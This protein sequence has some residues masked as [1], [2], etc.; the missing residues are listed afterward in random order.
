MTAASPQSAWT[1]NQRSAVIASFLG[2]MFDAFDFFLLLFV[3]HPIADEFGVPITEVTFAIVLTL[4]TRPI[5]AF[6]FGRAA[7]RYG[8]RPTLAIVIALYS[9]LE[10]VSAFAPNLVFLLFVRALFGI[11]MGGVW[12]VGVSLTMESIPSTARGF[13]SG[14]LQAGYPTGY[15]IAALAYA[16]LFPIVGWRGLFVIGAAPALL[17]VYVIRRVQESPSWRSTR[18][19]KESGTL[20][21]LKAHW[22]LA[23]YAVLLM[24]AF[25]FFSHSTQ[26]LYPTF[27]QVEHGLSSYAIGTIA[28][29]YN[30]GAIIGGLLFGSLS[31]RVGRRRAII[32]AALLSLPIVPLWAMSGNL[33]LL[34]IGAFLMQ[35]M[36]QGAW[37]VIPAHLNEL[38]P[39]DARGTFPGVVYQLG[40]L[41][42]SANTTLQAG[43]AAHLGNK[44]SLALA[45][46]AACAA[47]VVALLTAFGREAKGVR[48]A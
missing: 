6:I 13:V 7:D 19:S 17:S 39:A 35:F 9:A 14:L 15:L 1:A 23:I 26:D 41:F 24:T 45:G 21:V 46:T 12:G 18:H 33:V 34:A 20:G 31:E 25:N 4:A 2:W 16:F 11:A 22:K 5:G 48:L 27:L 10:L 47:I 44:Y 42:A 43:I 3:L 37:G 32:G 30:I 40:N 29:I 8:R 28:V 38:S 36:V